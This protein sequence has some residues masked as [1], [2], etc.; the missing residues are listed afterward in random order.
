[1]CSHGT[2]SSLTF[3]P[4][5]Q[6]KR[7][8]AGLLERSTV[9]FISFFLSIYFFVS[10]FYTSP[11]Y[12]MQSKC[13]SN[14]KIPLHPLPTHTFAIDAGLYTYGEK[15]VGTARLELWKETELNPQPF[16]GGVR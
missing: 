12:T 7:L 4:P 9:G 15:V 11:T 3:H 10:F 2:R 13:K 14:E 6:R 8:P 5:S 16:F 1:M